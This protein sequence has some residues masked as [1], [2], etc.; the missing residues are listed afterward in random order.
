[1]KTGQVL[2]CRGH[3]DTALDGIRAVLELA[4][5]TGPVLI[6]AY[7]AASAVNELR[8]ALELV[9]TISGEAEE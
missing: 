9:P 3:V 1:M 2:D 8:H 4:P 5:Q 7:R 6:A